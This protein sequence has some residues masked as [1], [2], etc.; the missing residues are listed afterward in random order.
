[1]FNETMVV[2]SAVSAFNNFAVVTPAFLWNA[3]LC[4][5]LFAAIYLFVR[6]FSAKCGIAPYVTVE[7]MTFWTVMLTAAWVVLMGGNYAVL[8]DNISLL[9]WVTAAVLFVSCIFIG[10]NT[11]A[12]KLPIWYGPK[13]ATNRRRWIMN[14]IV[15]LCCLVPVGLSGMLN[16]WG[17]ILQI[18]AVI[19]GLILGRYS[20]RQMR[21]VPC[22]LGVVF[23][24]V[25]AIL[26][27]SEL[28]RFGQLGNLTPIH[29]LWVLGTGIVIA[30]AMAINLVAP[31]GRVHNSAYIKLK[32]LMRFVLGLCMVLFI[33]TE[34]VPIFIAGV[35]AAF[36]SFG[37]SV[38][39]AESISG[40]LGNW[41]LA[42][43]I[44]L[45]GVLIDVATITAIGIVWIALPENTRRQGI[46]FLL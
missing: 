13:N 37:L 5:P 9:P 29:L 14:I 40:E 28:W 22:T 43:A 20:G 8:R 24:T 35:V 41:M 23:V 31:R 42:W 32:W 15:L 1:M 19:A 16:W 39:H 10:I 38:W 3:V 27:Q 21:A 7:R 34:A 18:V 45:F 17:P 11:R 33:L 4:V 36:I 12:I 46:G 6:R 2:A 44:I 26:M 30:A 25:I